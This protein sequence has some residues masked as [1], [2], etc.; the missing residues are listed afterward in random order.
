[1]GESG[2]LLFCYPTSFLIFSINPSSPRFWSTCFSLEGWACGSDTAHRGSHSL[3]Q[4]SVQGRSYS[5]I[6]ASEACN[7]PFK[8]KFIG[9]QL[10]YNVMLVSAVRQSESVI[11]IHI[12]SLFKILFP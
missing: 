8:E 11:H 1:M 9:V 6:R 2:H 10:T 12:S 5:P 7:F 3:T 4:W